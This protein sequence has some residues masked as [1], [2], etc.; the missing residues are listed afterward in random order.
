MVAINR[1]DIMSTQPLHQPNPR[2]L[3]PTLA[4]K[5][6][7]ARAAGAVLRRARSWH[8]GALSLGFLLAAL[9]PL[10]AEDEIAKAAKR[11]F[12][13]KQDAVIW[14]TVVA[15]ISVTAEGGKDTPV[16]IPDREQK[17]ETLGT[18]ISPDGLVVTAL[19][20]LDPSK[21]LSGREIRTPNGMV[22][23]EASVALKEALLVMPD[24]TEVPA[25][26][27]MKDF[28]LDLAFLKAK[29]DSKEAKGVTFKS[30]DLANRTSVGIMDDVVNLSRTDEVLNRQ[31]SVTRGLV[32]A[33]TKKPREFLRVTGIV[34][35]CPT[36][37][38]DG[39]VV[40]LAVNRSMKGKSPVTIVLPAADVIEIAE[41]ARKEAAKLEKK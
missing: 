14:I 5:P 22:K 21:E 39:K 34:P 24:G 37:G 38:V 30:I 33:L 8:G 28:D 4:R 35:G 23:I 2:R 36:F 27:L 7:P 29:P 18:I 40:G 3:T 17:A 32:I 12:A 25:E 31:P 9:L 11:I 16:N 15:K 6:S 19:S 26:V 20:T 41:Q 13:E 10:R 1:Q